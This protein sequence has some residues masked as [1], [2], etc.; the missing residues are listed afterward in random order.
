ML[1]TSLTGRSGVPGGSLSPGLLAVIGAR[2]WFK[3]TAFSVV[4][5]LVWCIV[6]RLYDGGRLG[7]GFQLQSRTI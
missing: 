1:V 6:C 3:G 7:N 5:E 4:R 2:D